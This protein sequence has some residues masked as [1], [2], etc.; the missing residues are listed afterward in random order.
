MPFQITKN[1]QFKV[2]GSV[3]QATYWVVNRLNIDRM[4]PSVQLEV[5]GYADKSS[6]DADVTSALLVQFV[7]YPSEAITQYPF[8]PTYLVTTFGSS[9]PGAFVLAAEAM[10]LQHPF[11]AGAVQV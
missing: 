8:D 3:L 11:F 4:S 9:G 2:N 1:T 10:V 6:H 5:H 7:S